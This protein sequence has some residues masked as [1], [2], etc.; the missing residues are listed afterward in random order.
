ME[1]IFLIVALVKTTYA[2]YQPYIDGKYVYPKDD[3][4]AVFPFDRSHVCKIRMVARSGSYYATVENVYNIIDRTPLFG[5]TT[6]DG[7]SQQIF[8]ACFKYKQY[9]YVVYA[10]ANT[11][12]TTIMRGHLSLSLN[13]P[14]KLDFLCYDHILSSL[15][16]IAENQLFKV[17]L[18]ALELLWSNHST[19][20]YD[21]K[22]RQLERLFTHTGIHWLNIDDEDGGN[23]TASNFPSIIS[24]S[25]IVNRT[26]F[27][28]EQNRLYLYR[29]EIRLHPENNFFPTTIVPIKSRVPKI[30]FL[31]FE[32]PI[33]TSSSSMEGFEENSGGNN[34]PLIDINIPLPSESLGKILLPANS[35]ANDG[36]QNLHIEIIMLR[37]FLYCLDLIVILL[38]LYFLRRQILQDKS[39]QR[40]GDEE[41]RPMTNRRRSSFSPSYHS[42]TSAML[43]RP[44]IITPATT[45]IT[46]AP[47]NISS[48]S[49]S[50]STSTQL[51]C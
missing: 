18:D 3:S 30:S 33:M 48:S 8:L 20:Q 26:L 34:S 11:S 4:L 7:E 50:K 35:T 40:N 46:T 22:R 6:G 43:Q 31:L 5:I 47:L 45:K 49:S 2:D 16:A 36:E 41:L 39:H 23:Y 19:S 9:S 51:E 44:V 29:T 38:I 10:S 21:G 25:M 17:N 24:D 1:F 27:Y 14:F 32:N 13:F 42:T 12:L 15:Y 28:Y 37:V